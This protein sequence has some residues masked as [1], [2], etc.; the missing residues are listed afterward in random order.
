ML[1]ISLWKIVNYDKSI[2]YC[3]FMK[4]F[5]FSFMRLIERFTARTDLF[6]NLQI[7]ECSKPNPYKGNMNNF[8]RS[9]FPRKLCRD[10][11][12]EAVIFFSEIINIYS[13]SFTTLFTLFQH[14]NLNDIIY[15]IFFPVQFKMHVSIWYLSFLVFLC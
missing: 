15:L 13:N 10:E 4:Y 6:F 2:F 5:T 7:K 3:K 9:I 8:Q 1:E 14:R 11:D 12:Y